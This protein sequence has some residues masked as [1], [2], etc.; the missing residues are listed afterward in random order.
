MIL[1][2]ENQIWILSRYLCWS[3][4]IFPR[5]R[6]PLDVFIDFRQKLGICEQWVLAAYWAGYSLLH[7]WKG[8]LISYTDGLDLLVFYGFW[9]HQRNLILA[10]NSIY[11]CTAS[12]VKFVQ[13]IQIWSI[14]KVFAFESVQ[15]FVMVLN[16]WEIFLT[17]HRIFVSFILPH[18]N[19]Y[20]G[21]FFL[22]VELL[23]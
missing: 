19:L 14:R 5:E 3:I 8:L 11:L 15:P 7:Y 4:R 17:K 12:C 23:L 9:Q 16:R 18:F 10:V 20:L 1:N 6:K 21:H 13:N 22:W 2:H